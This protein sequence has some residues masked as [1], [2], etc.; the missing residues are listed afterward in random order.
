L[1]RA[2]GGACS[3]GS[4]GGVGEDIP[5][6]WVDFPRAV[7]DSSRA[8]AA[9]PHDLGDNDNTKSKGSGQECPLHMIPVQNITPTP[10]VT[11]VL[12]QLY[13]LVGLP[14]PAANLK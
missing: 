14:W 2:E 6:R 5:V 1:T 3:P 13:R 12:F 9:V 4:P 7:E 10:P 8:G 11:R